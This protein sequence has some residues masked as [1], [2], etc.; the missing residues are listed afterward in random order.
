[1][2]RPGFLVHQRGDSVGVAAID[3]S[4]GMT[5]VGTHLD[6]NDKMTVTLRDSVPLGHKLALADILMGDDV[7]E[8]GYTIGSAT[9]DILKG[10]HVHTHN[11]RSKRW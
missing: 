10:D 5:S 4:K 1:M 6:G 3:L 8:Y 9:A 2:E 7:V 11:L